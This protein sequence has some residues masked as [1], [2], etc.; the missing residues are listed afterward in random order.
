MSDRINFG[1]IKEVIQPPNLIENQID[2]FKEF[3]QLDIASNQ[4]KQVGLEA[5]FS[6]V[7]PIESYDSRCHLEYV[8]YN[9]TAPRESEIEAIREGV[10][11]SASLYVKL[12]L[13][14]E[15]HIKDEEIYMGELPMITE[16]GSFIINGA[17]R[18]IVSQLHRSPG[19]AFEES[20]HTSGKTLHAFRIIPDRGTWLEV[21]FDQNDLL[22]VYLDRR[23]RRRKFLLTTLL[24]A[25]GYS[26]DADI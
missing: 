21:Q 1:Q 26:S 16:R 3:L 23:R 14:E 10:T 8:S 24:R 25:M 18:V 19:I 15:D 20:V 9:V 11:Y 13:R 6:E 2:S 17:E 12:R 4:R 5:V 7:F 22:Y